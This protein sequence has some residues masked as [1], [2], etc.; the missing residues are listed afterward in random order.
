[1]SVI[2]SVYCVIWSGYCGEGRKEWHSWHW[3]EEVGTWSL[4][5]LIGIVN[6]FNLGHMQMLQCL[7]HQ[8]SVV[9]LWCC[10]VQ[11]SGASRFDCRPVCLCHSKAYQ[12]EFR[13]G[14]LHICQER[15]PPNRCFTLLAFGI[16]MSSAVCHLTHVLCSFY[17]WHCCCMFGSCNDVIDIWRAQGG[18]WL[19]VFHI[20]RWKHFWRLTCVLAART[21]CGDGTVDHCTGPIHQCVVSF[22]S[23]SYLA[24]PFIQ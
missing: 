1:M 12:A 11:V 2:C 24:S 4:V 7:Q 14:Y 21:M 5:A 16:F 6:I 23:L 8:V 22:C 13:E 19:S 18:G 20:Q 10:L 9:D 17:H 15:S 3:Q